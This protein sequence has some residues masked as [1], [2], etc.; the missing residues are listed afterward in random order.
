MKKPAPDGACND[1][2]PGR[3]SFFIYI[4]KLMQILMQFFTDLQPFSAPATRCKK[5]LEAATN[6]HFKG[7]S[8]GADEGT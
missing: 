6:G 8:L 2:R 1:D 7:F 5:A 3:V 4:F